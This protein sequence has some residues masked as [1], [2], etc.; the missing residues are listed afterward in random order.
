MESHLIHCH[1]HLVVPGRVGHCDRQVVSHR[2]CLV[3][4]E[5]LTAMV[6]GRLEDV[7]QSPCC[8]GM[9]PGCRLDLGD[10]VGWEHLGCVLQVEIAST[11][12]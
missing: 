7:L 4:I 10:Q 1:C 9:D 8:L 6:V 5:V 3:E 12:L 2:R 11:C